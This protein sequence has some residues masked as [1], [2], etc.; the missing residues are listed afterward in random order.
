MDNTITNTRSPVKERKKGKHLNDGK[1]E[2]PASGHG[3]SRSFHN[4]R[5]PN[6][7]SIED[8]LLQVLPRKRQSAL[9]I[10]T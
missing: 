2:R 5:W 4:R 1:D 10:G 8:A 7:A 9:G 3:R 6:T